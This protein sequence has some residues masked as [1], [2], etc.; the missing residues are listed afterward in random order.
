[1]ASVPDEEPPVSDVPSFVAEEPDEP[2]V[3]AADEL[4]SEL[5]AEPESALELPVEAFAPESVLPASFVVALSVVAG[6]VAGVVAGWSCVWLVTA[7]V[8]WA[9]PVAPQPWPSV[10]TPTSAAV[11]ATAAMEATITTAVAAM[12]R[13]PSRLTRAAE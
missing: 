7:A 11:S 4:A 9:A 13:L 1:M 5:V 2:D 8:G 12:R 6:A 10:A 3:V